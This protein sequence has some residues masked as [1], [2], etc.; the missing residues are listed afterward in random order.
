MKAIRTSSGAKHKTPGSISRPRKSPTGGATAKTRI[1]VRRTPSKRKTVASAGTTEIPPILLEGDRPV[2]PPVSGPGEKFALGPTPPSQQFGTEATELPSSYGTK[3]LFL[4][5]RDP[6]WLY[7]QWDLTPVQQ[8]RYNALAADKHLVLRVHAD[9]VQGALASE[10]HVH[11]ESRHWFVHVERA[12]AKYVAELGYYRKYR[13]SRL[14]TRIAT[15]GATLTPPDSVSSDTSIEFATIPIEVP[16]DELV[17]MIRETARKSLPLAQA[18]EELRKAGHPQLPASAAMAAPAWTAAQ[19]RALAEVICMDDVRRVWIGSLE[20]T[21]LIRR[22]LEREIS[23]MG[24]AQF[25]LPTSPGGAITSVSSPFGGMPPGQKGFWFNI[26]A[27]LIIYGATE[28]DATVS[29]GGRA[30]KLRSDGSFSYRFALPD[31]R[32]EMPV[33]AVAAD[34]TDGRAADLKFTRAT[35]ILGDVGTHPQDPSLKTPTPENV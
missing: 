12:S 23:S 30:I 32:Y 1:E 27:E 21:E 20:I 10:T 7:A 4:T 2:P 34:A 18:L 6:H 16:F 31:G 13:N 14:W 24:L 29:I 26:N 9:A 5:A 17:R 15:S 25:G 8:A 22:Q 28:P 19:E 33:V 35:E 3:R 11:P